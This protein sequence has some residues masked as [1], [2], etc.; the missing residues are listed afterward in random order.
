MPKALIV[1]CNG[2]D[3]ILLSRF[4]GKK[5]YHIV[6]IDTVSYDRQIRHCV[7]TTDV[8][9]APAVAGVLAEF[10]P[11]E[12]YY[13]AAFHHS[14][15]D[16]AIDD[17]ELVPQSFEINTL[18]LHNFLYGVSRECPEAR[19]F[20]AA[21]SRVFGD[22]K[23]TPQDETTPMEPTCPYGIS[24]AAGVHLCRYYRR[25]RG[26]YCS[27]GFLYNHESSLR[28]IQFLS[29]KIVRAAVNVKRGLQD[30]VTVGS[31]HSLVDWGYAPDYVAAMWEMLQ[32]QRPDDFVVA[33]GA[34]HSVREL[35][36]VAFEEMGLS[37]EKHV[38]EDRSLL[39][40]VRP[41]RPLQGNAAKLRARTGWHPQVSFPEMVRRLV[42]EEIRHSDN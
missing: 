16:P 2:Q 15:E 40:E 25:E 10:R 19:L 34:L 1:G 8:R 37:W 33:S 29:R 5:S 13:L 20:Y 18:A 23:T 39:R 24:K 3:G 30:C 14:A 27:T 7:L 11:D 36:A 17:Q 31:L 28:P 35:A 22:P 26:T 21:S 32:L 42:T 41:G 4:L 6:G 38:I 9:S 12:I